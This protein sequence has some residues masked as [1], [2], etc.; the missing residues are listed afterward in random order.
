MF[1]KIN[2][3]LGLNLS[4]ID[5]MGNSLSIPYRYD[6]H[7]IE[8]NSGPDMKIHYKADSNNKFFA[9]DRFVKNIFNN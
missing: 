3:I 1:L 7:V 6:G 4:G 5:Y 8:V 2:K 9:V